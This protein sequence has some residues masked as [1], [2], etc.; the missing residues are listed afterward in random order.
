MRPGADHNNA[1]GE[2]T[3]IRIWV[4]A[5]MIRMRQGSGVWKAER[6][7]ILKIGGHIM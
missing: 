5:D 1:G 3:R 4:A 6:E 2:I 7:H